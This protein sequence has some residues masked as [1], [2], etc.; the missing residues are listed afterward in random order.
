MQNIDAFLVS[1]S[2]AD[3]RGLGCGMIVRGDEVIIVKEDE[4]IEA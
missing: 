3:M 1:I 2:M 4:T